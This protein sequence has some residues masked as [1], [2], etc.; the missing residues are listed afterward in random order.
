[1]GN[2]GTPSLAQLDPVAGTFLVAEN[3][4]KEQ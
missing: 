2:K 4:S 3:T 1:M